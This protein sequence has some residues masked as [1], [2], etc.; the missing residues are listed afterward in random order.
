MFDLKKM[1]HNMAHVEGSICEA[2]IIREVSTFI[3][4]YFEP[5]ISLKLTRVP[6]N[7][8]GDDCM[9][10]RLSIFIQ[11]CPFG[12]IGKVGY[13]TDADQRAVHL[14]VL[15]NCTEVGLYVQ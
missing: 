6:H 14:Y 15:L 5:K 4:Y 10:G 13:Y 2:Y 7:D 11:G 12:P 8:E 3:S 1:V 9:E